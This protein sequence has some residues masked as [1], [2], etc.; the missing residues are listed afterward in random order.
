M[1][2]NGHS[3]GDCPFFGI[4]RHVHRG[5][6]FVFIWKNMLRVSAMKT[7]ITTLLFLS[8]LFAS[9]C[10]TFLV[11]PDVTP[12]S[13]PR[14]LATAT[15]DNMVELTWLANPEPDVS[16]YH[17]YVSETP[18]GS[19]ALIGT[20]RQAY[21][22]DDGAVN[23]RLYYYAVQAFDVNGN[24]SELSHDV[25]YDIPRPEGY[26]VAIANFRTN[27][28]RAGYDFST[29]SIGRYDDQFTD[30]FFEFH[31]GS[32][33]LNVWED[34][35]IQDMGYTFSLL[36]V[37]EAPER[38]WSP[39]RDVRVIPGHTY[40]VWTWDD[41]FAKIRVVDVSPTR[42]IFDWAYQ[43]RKGS[44]LLKGRSATER[45]AISAGGGMRERGRR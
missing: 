8:G 7:I 2:R 40:V 34:T 11:E 14:G 13:P 38:G 26:D 16:G 24:E 36:S 31:D 9:G 43:L 5:M 15:G 22:L 37:R 42:V 33:Y 44:P 41:H 10:Q 27:P 17:V 25:A 45:A 20:T 6:P 21:L 39:T 30:F 4:R 1:L 3:W 35:D 29:Y 32:H 19:Y 18:D 23:G 12:P 28:S